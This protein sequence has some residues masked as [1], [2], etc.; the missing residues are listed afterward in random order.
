MKIAIYTRS[1]NNN[2]LE[3]KYNINIISNF[4]QK[5][6]YRI[7]GVTWDLCRRNFKKYPKLNNLIQISKSIDVDAI[8]VTSYKQIATNKKGYLDIIHQL[9]KNGIKLI[10]IDAE[11]RMDEIEGSNFYTEKNTTMFKQVAQAL[12]NQHLLVPIH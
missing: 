12:M 8:V 3:I 6:E 1:M 11:N 10:V 5:N 7:M 2:P 4:A 9:Q